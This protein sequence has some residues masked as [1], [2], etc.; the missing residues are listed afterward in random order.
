MDQ[1]PDPADQHDGGQPAA[2]RRHDV[3]VRVRRSPRFGVFMLL[4]AVVG[5]LVAWLVSAVQ[6]PGVDE[7]GQP[8]D[9]TGILGLA[10]V[11]GVVLGVGVGAVVALLVD[12]ALAKRGRM[13]MAEQ[14]DVEAP[15]QPQAAVAPSD[16]GEASFEHLAHDEAAEPERRP[17]PGEPGDDQAQERDR[18]SGI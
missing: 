17:L 16:A 12:R 5:A 1:T 8:V 18:P 14:T 9:T 2:Q 7:A 6:A 10:I 15:E 3:E 4:G 13:L 11:V